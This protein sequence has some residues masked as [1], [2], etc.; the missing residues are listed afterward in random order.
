MEKLYLKLS[1]QELDEY[2]KNRTA[3][4]KYEK[5]RIKKTPHKRSF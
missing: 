1:R 3:V 2:N 5:Q 4:K